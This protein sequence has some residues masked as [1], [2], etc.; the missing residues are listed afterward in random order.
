MANTL[1]AYA[2]CRFS[3][4]DL[5]PDHGDWPWEETKVAGCWVSWQGPKTARLKV[6]AEL[7]ETN[8][9][10]LGLL[11]WPLVQIAFDEHSNTYTYRRTDV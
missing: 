7:L 8:P 9:G 6:A 3:Q 1:P 4:S 11:P 5:A 2:E 10:F